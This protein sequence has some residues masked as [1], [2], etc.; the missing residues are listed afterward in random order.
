MTIKEKFRKKY[1]LVAGLALVFIFIFAIPFFVDGS[2]FRIIQNIAFA[3]A[4]VCVTYLMYA[5]KCPKCREKVGLL[6][7]MNSAPNFC[8]KC[9]LDFNGEKI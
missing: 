5:I 8:P 2:I 4:G 9:G 6:T 3:G 1:R 7:S